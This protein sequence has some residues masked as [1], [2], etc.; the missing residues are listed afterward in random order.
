MAT[1]SYVKRLWVI[2]PILEHR[3]PKLEKAKMALH[4][5]VVHLIEEDTI[6]HDAIEDSMSRVVNSDL[7]SQDVRL[8]NDTSLKARDDH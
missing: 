5:A 3:F 6:D 7:G 2:G 4:D 8:A 1:T